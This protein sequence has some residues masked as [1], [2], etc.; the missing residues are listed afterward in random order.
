MT[1]CDVKFNFVKLSSWFCAITCS[2]ERGIRH[3]RTHLIEYASWE[4]L[5]RLGSAWLEEEDMNKAYWGVICIICGAPARAPTHITNH[6]GGS[7]IHVTRRPRGWAGTFRSMHTYPVARTYDGVSVCARGFP[8][9][10]KVTN[11]LNSV[12]LSCEIRQTM[13]ATTP[14]RAYRA[15]ARGMAS[16]SPSA[17]SS[18]P[19]K[20]ARVCA[21]S[22]KSAQAGVATQIYGRK[23][24]TV[25]ICFLIAIHRVWPLI[26][27]L[28]SRP[29]IW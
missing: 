17:T 6:P 27:G 10:L 18:P 19:Q 15:Q 29:K 23:D 7:P 21:A 13:S 25:K 4:I 3:A 22:C 14:C 2:G 1:L 24:W 11:K 5:L 26:C 12:T 20:T 8:F 28:A 9:W 16:L